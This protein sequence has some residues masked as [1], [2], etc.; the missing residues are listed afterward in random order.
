MM[1][2]IKIHGPQKIDGVVQISG[3]KNAALPLLAAA[4]LSDEGLTLKNVPPLQDVS[5]MLSLLT[6]FGATNH[7]K[8]ESR[9][10]MEVCIK[11][12]SID[13]FV[14]PYEI[15]KKMRA[16]ILA[17]GPMLAKFAQCKVSLPG[18]CAIGARPIDIHLKG[19]EALG[20]KIR[21][22]NG[23]VHATVPSGL[24][25]MDF[26]F[27]LVSVTGTEN[28]LMAAVLAEGTTVLRNAAQEPEVVDLANCLNAMGAKISGQ[29][30]DTIV[31]KGVTQLK[32]TTYTV[33][34]DRIEAGTYALAAGITRG[35]VD[36]VGGNFRELLPAFT[37]TAEQAGLVFEDTNDGTRVKFG[38]EIVPVNFET[39]PHP[40][41]PTDLQAQMMAYL[42]LAK[43]ESQ[44][45]ENIWENRF[46]HATELLKMGADIQ[47][48]G[49][50]AKVRGVKALSGATVQATDLRAS[51]S[52]VLAG[53]AANG[54]SVVDRAYHLERGYSRVKE[55]LAG[56][57]V[58][59]E[60]MG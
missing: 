22:E 17:L 32:W 43:G 8:Q 1:T 58:E 52:L 41:Y 34:P 45:M 5:T 10:A 21:L 3:A 49:S 56:C 46:M 24:R 29:G 50:L 26:T 15:V 54:E 37:K 23:Y 36:L 60:L 30:T 48:G 33:L 4:I 6:S 53:L 55:K 42:C 19:L 47:L 35:C 14:A 51:F 18:G 11:T 31:V 38:G 25:G 20:A 9:Y 28:V 27:P 57:G 16:S 13:S 44:I 59:I 7:I 40:G 2:K 39:G 12:D